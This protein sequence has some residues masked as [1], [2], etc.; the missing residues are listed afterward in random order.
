[1]LIYLK[2]LNDEK[3]DKNEK[4]KL[5]N[6]NF[7]NYNFG[8]VKIISNTYRLTHQYSFGEINPLCFIKIILFLQKILVI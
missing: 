7:D 1:M 4:I 3:I 8:K 5:K 2:F 6:I